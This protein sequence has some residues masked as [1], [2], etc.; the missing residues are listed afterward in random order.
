MGR[1]KPGPLAVADRGCW[2]DRAWAQCVS[3]GM[4]GLVMPET[5]GGAGQGPPPKHLLELGRKPKYQGGCPGLDTGPSQAGAAQPWGSIRP[6]GG[7]VSSSQPNSVLMVI[8]LMEKVGTGCHYII[9][10]LDWFELPDSFL[11]VMEHPEASQ[12]LLQ[13]LLK[14]EFLSEEV[15]T[16]Y[17]VRC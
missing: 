5:S 1:D 10:L 14:Q 13:F 11:L 15:H 17:S 7:I 3:W 12:D 6:A 16:G 4:V 8:V 9:Q 2:G